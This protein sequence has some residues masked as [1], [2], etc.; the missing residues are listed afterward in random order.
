[1]ERWRLAEWRKIGARR[2]S[3]IFGGVGNGAGEAKRSGHGCLAG[4]RENIG[5]SRVGRKEIKGEEE[6]GVGP[7]DACRS[8]EAEDA[9]LVSSG[10][11]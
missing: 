6:V 1:M 3:R 9:S 11:R 8:H 4:E 2:R 7:A 10:G 5:D